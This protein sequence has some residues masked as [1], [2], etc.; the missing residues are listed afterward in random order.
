LSQIGRNPV[1]TFSP[2][3]LNPCQ[4]GTISVTITSTGAPG[5][6]VSGTLYLDDFVQDVPPSAFGQSGG[7]EL[8]AFPYSYT[9]QI[10]RCT[11]ATSASGVAIQET[12]PV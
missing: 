9:N 2:L 4:T 6:V 8:A 12:A 11:I 5:T 10:R 7:D 3:V 1:A